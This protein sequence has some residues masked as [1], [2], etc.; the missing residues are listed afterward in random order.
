MVTLNHFAFDIYKKTK[1]YEKRE[2]FPEFM[3]IKIKKFF[4]ISEL[5]VIYIIIFG[6]K[7]IIILVHGNSFH[8]S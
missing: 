7:D 1:P 3:C 4:F 8:G 6:K 2:Q 5:L